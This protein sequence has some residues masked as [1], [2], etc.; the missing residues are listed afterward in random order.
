MTQV[1]T[2]IAGLDVG[3]R[4]SQYH[5]ADEASGALLEEGKV[6]TRPESLRTHFGAVPPMRIVVET[7]THSAWIARLLQSLG[8]DVV[9]ADARRLRFIYMSD[10]K[11]DRI[12]ARMLAKVG[13]LDRSLLHP[14]RVRSRE[15]DLALCVLRSRDVVVGARTKLMNSVRG[16]VKRTGTRLPRLSAEAFGAKAKGHLPDELRATIEPLLEMIEQMTA[17][18][19]AY[20]ARVEAMCEARPETQR[21]RQVA[22]VGPVTAL[23]YVLVI[24]DPNRFARSRDVGPYLGFVPRLDVS[25]QTD[26]QLRISKAG[27]MLLR[28]LLVGSAHYI[29]GPFG[30]DTDLRRWGLAAGAR[31]GS[32]GKKR[33]AVAVARRLAVLL[34]HLWVSGEDYRPLRTASVAPATTTNGGLEGGT[35]TDASA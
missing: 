13:R 28:R 34:H 29:L 3:D 21:L 33:A 11:D 4:F 17:T 12:D 6:M 9:V 31:G 20:D 14:V 8:H 30:P 23:A 1:I 35:M 15:S 32:H 5:I 22:G 18:V 10:R 25:G 24:D 16:Q 27:H 19:R 7:G 2:M 26:R